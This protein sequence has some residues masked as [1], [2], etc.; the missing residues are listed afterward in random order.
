MIIEES[1]KEIKKSFKSHKTIFITGHRNLDLDA[2]GS[3]IGILALC[4]KLKK[5]A[6]IIIDD[7]KHELGVKKVLSEINSNQIIKSSDIDKYKSNKDL[8][9]IVD[10]NKK[11]LLQN[12]NLI[13]IIPESIIIDHH[14]VSDKTITS[15]YKV[16]DNS[17]S[18]ACEMITELLKKFKIKLTAHEATIILSGI[19][20]DTNNFVVKTT[21]NTYK[22]AYYLTT[23]GADPTKVQYYLKQDINDYILRQDLIRNIIIKDN[24]AITVGN[25]NIK[26]KREELAKMADTLLQFNGIHASYVLGKI[27]ENIVGLSARSDNDIDVSYIAEKLGGGG[28]KNDAA[29]QIESYDIIEVFKKL[30]KF[31]NG[32]E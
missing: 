8:L 14:E 18:S 9:V 24:I 2:L 25:E 12:E 16:I 26:Y 13:N 22:N 10:T 15:S 5:K 4:T 23:Y 17:S 32:D 1:F 19:V 21:S 28:D 30:K 20:L 29:A 11:V 6:Y 31:I 3:C 27:D 7:E